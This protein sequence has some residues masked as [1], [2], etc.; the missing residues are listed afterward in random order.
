M[1]ATVQIN[2]GSAFLTLA[3]IRDTVEN[4]ER[5]IKALREALKVR[6]EELSPEIYHDIERNL[7]WLYSLSKEK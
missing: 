4:C 5:A 2:L 6:T 7:R 3:E 1:Y